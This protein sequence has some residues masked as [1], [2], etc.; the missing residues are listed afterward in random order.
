M[1]M[2]FQGS[3]GSGTGGAVVVGANSAGASAVAMLR[4]AVVVVATVVVVV[5][6]IA[7]D[8]G[9][10]LVAARGVERT[11]T[12]SPMSAMVTAT[13]AR[14][15]C[16]RTSPR[17][18]DHGRGLVLVEPA[19][20][21]V[22]TQSDDVGWGHVPALDGVRGIAV[23]AVLL[24]HGGVS[25]A[26]GGFLGVDA[27]FVLSGLLITSLLLDE[28]HRDQRVDLGRFWSRRA[29][30]L[31]PALIVVVAAT[32]LYAALLAPRG[33]LDGLRKDALATLFY[34][35]NWRFIQAGADYFE[36]TAAPSV[37]RHAGS[38]S[39]EE[40][41]YLAWPLVLFA[42]ARSRARVWWTAG[43]A[44]AGAI[45]S[46]VAMA[47]IFDPADDVSRAYFGTDTRVHVVLVGCV[48]AAVVAVVR[49]RGG[50]QSRAVCRLLGFAAALGA[51]GFL[52]ASATVEGTEPLLF[53]GGF[54]VL[55]VA[56]AL[57]LAHIV[58][59][60]EGWS[61]WVFAW[62]PLRAVGLV[63]YGLYLWHWPVFL[64]VT[65]DRTGLSGP[66]LLGAKVA[67]TTVLALASYVIVERPIRRGALP[68]MQGLAIGVTA[69]AVAA[70]A[71]LVGTQLPP[72]EEPASAAART[73]SGYP[74][75]T[76]P[77]RDPGEPSRVLIVGDSVGKTLADR[78][79]RRAARDGLAFTNKAVLGCG[80]VRGGPYKYFGKQLQ[81]LRQCESWPTQWEGHV[82]RVDPDVVLA[83]VGR[84]EV[85]DRVHD[86]T[87]TQLGQPAFDAYIESE[88]E[89]MV[90]VLGA[91]NA[92]VA[93]TTAPYF[94]RGERPDGGRWP[95]DDPAR[96][97]RFNAILR[98]V[99]DRHRERVALLDLNAQT[100]R[101]GVYTA[102]I[103][104]VSL[105]FDGV[106]FSPQ[107]ST[108][109]A[110]WLIGALLEMSPPVN[111]VTPG[112]TAPT[113]TP[114][115]QP[116]TTAPRSTTPS[117]TARPSASTT[118][119]R[120]ATTQPPPSTTTTQTTRPPPPTIVPTLPGR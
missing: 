119:P 5:S 100:S 17:L 45:A 8:E 18:R 6:T 80:I 65:N 83:V 118:A 44:A 70:A 53:R 30:R 62:P 54:L 7:C 59:V 52:A 61:A 114:P 28:A 63:S 92:I 111:G 86:G 26:R 112:V 23:I 3:G 64:T 14:D 67:V 78:I 11:T 19:S 66:A 24:F 47:F 46:A 37:L 79:A 99:V 43:V 29:R 15:D 51:A 12:A 94:L 101:G 76:R 109:L 74:V 91:G 25:W 98:R 10:E 34:V 87:W 107:G 120:P 93:V 117:T 90:S 115:L 71:V 9:V 56:V 22:G 49:R 84:W 55:A 2:T 116:A 89:R 60:P 27:F 81:Q 110:P 58:L 48:L 82:A 41:F 85:M 102:V 4:S 42:I 13:T 95:E 97:D 21:M 1:S 106:H 38:L 31:L 96:V 88:L 77:A 20:T 57:L 40:Q 105:R 113:T 33:A 35:A 73:A 50:I 68:R 103:D 32:G 72:L 104:G 108:W 75:S 69:V 39:I 16:R 36:A